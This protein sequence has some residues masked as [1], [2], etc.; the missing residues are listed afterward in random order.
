MTWT[1][2]L[3]ERRQTFAKGPGDSLPK[4]PKAPF[5]GFVSTPEDTSEN[6]EADTRTRLHRLA[7]AEGLPAACVDTIPDEELPLYD[8]W[9]DTDLLLPLH[10]RARSL[11]IERGTP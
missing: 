3:A 11:G 8:V 5:V 9:S 7:A 10:L 4:L 1:D 2:R 6:I